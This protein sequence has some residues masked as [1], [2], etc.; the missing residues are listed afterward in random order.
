M[1]LLGLAPG[2]VYRAGRVTATLVRSYRTV[3]P[4]PA[5]SRAIGG[6]LS[7]ALSVGSPPLGVTQH[8]A[9]WSSDFPRSRDRSPGGLTISFYEPSRFRRPASQPV[10]PAMPAATSASQTTD[11]VGAGL[12]PILATKTMRAARRRPVTAPWKRSE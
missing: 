10:R 3:S 2:G 5:P 12:P 1:S 7:V 4:L 8:P 9:L 6:L 11:R